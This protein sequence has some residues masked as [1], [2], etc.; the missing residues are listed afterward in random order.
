M[1]SNGAV[2]ISWLND[3]QTLVIGY[4]VYRSE[5]SDGPWDDTTK[6]GWTTVD[7]FVDANIEKGKKYFYSI[8]SANGKGFS[9]PTKPVSFNVK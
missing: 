9:E 2:N 7:N 1:L 4:K 3:K 8:K 5:N 6:I